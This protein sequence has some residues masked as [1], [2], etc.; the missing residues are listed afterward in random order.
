[1]SSSTVPCIG[2]SLEVLWLSSRDIEHG[3]WPHVRNHTNSP[4]RFRQLKSV[5]YTFQVR[6]SSDCSL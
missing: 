3:S 4:I 1:M 5:A 6:N 2:W